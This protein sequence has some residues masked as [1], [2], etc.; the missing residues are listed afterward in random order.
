MT[1]RRVVLAAVLLAALAASGTSCRRG[2]AAPGATPADSAEVVPAEPATL[3]VRNRHRADVVVY[4]YRGNVRTRLGQ[5]T[6]AG[7]AQWTLPREVVRDAGGIVFVADPIGGRTSLFSE[8][9]VLRPGAR[10]VWTLESGL[11]RASLAIY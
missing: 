2:G 8:R 6:T 11:A 9:V 10:V 5:V 4:V 1:R 7:A 3:Q